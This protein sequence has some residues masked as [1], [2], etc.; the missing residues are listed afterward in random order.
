[1]SETCLRHDVRGGHNNVGW[2]KGGGT[3]E[4]RVV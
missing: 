2:V 3:I 1:M 4:V